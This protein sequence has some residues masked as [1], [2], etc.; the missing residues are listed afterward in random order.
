MRMKRSWSRQ[1]LANVAMPD[2]YV[3][4]LQEVHP[5]APSLIDYTSKGRYLL[6]RKE[7]WLQKKPLLLHKR[8]ELL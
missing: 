2:P 5:K 6:Q 3:V 8:N 7:K 4:H 1:E